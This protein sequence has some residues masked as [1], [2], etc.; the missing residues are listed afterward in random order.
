[1]DQT[2]NLSVHVTADGTVVEFAA[3]NGN[4]TA[5]NIESL[6]DRLDGSVRDVLLAWCHDRRNDAQ[7]SQNRDRMLAAK[8]DH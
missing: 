7:I 3:R 8:V 2:D 6:A 1:M 4:S 5:L